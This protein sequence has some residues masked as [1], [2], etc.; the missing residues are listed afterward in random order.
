[1]RNEEFAVGKSKVAEAL[2]DRSMG[3]RFSKMTS[4][5]TLHCVLVVPCIQLRRPAIPVFLAKECRFRQ[6][7]ICEKLIVPRRLLFIQPHE[8]A[9]PSCAIMNHKY[10][11]NSKDSTALKLFSVSTLLSA[12]AE[13]AGRVADVSPQ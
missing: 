11:H 6:S 1:M 12:Q 8:R 5:M 4:A 2:V 3:H 10:I 7:A 9:S 13:M